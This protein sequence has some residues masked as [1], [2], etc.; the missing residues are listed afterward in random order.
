MFS[1]HVYVASQ[2]LTDLIRLGV[3]LA[4]KIYFSWVISYEILDDL[5]Q[6][7]RHHDFRITPHG[8]ELLGLPVIAVPGEGR[9]ELV[10]RIA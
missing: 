10:K 2:K 1:R 3:P 8:N 5:A 4:D 6:N 9:L 7:A